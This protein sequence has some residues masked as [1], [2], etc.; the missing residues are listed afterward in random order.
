ML[1]IS[2]EK[3]CGESLRYEGTYDRIEQSRREDNASLPRG[4]WQTDL[5]RADWLAVE[6]TCT[7]ALAKRSKD[8]Q[9]VAWLMQ[10]WIHLNGFAG[11]ARGFTLMTSLCESFWD[12]L[13]PRIEDGDLEFRL[14]PIRWVNEKL[15][16]DFKL[17][18]LTSPFTDDVPTFCWADWE[19]VLSAP[20]ADKGNMESDMTRFQQSLQMTSREWLVELR[21]A[22]AETI[23]AAT[24]FDQL[25]DVKAGKLSPGTLQVR[26]VAEAVAELLDSVLT[27][28][29]SG[30]MVPLR[31]SEGALQESSSYAE[32][33]FA[34]LAQ[35]AP[36][37]AIRTRTEAYRLLE[38]AADFLQRTE[39]HSPTPYLIRRAVSWGKMSFNELL[40]ELIRNN[41]ELSEIVR[42][43]QVDVS[44][45]PTA[46][47]TP[48][49][50][51]VEVGKK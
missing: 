15:P 36:I 11:A 17:I 21:G 46:T 41:S 51:N 33:E 10:A 22:V 19:A 4:V 6:A 25:I 29:E 9:L 35:E 34:S 26:S 42:L 47:G 43:L 2:A 13:F 30:T 31:A 27:H 38:E 39:P 16:L 3:P 45:V 50:T 20:G 37:T 7:E 24:S 12:E 14:A 23:A 44:K 49:H 40:P 5:K 18:P 48:T 32:S 8:L 28:T 1:P